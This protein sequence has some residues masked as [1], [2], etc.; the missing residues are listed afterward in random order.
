MQKFIVE[1]M[2]AI[3]S[4]RE[5]GMGMKVKFFLIKGI[6]DKCPTITTSIPETGTESKQPIAV[7]TIILRKGRNDSRPVCHV[8]FIMETMARIG[9]IQPNISSKKRVK[10]VIPSLA[11]DAHGPALT[12]RIPKTKAM[13][14]ICR[15]YTG[16]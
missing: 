2:H 6:G 8:I 1:G 14:N 11:Q 5:N 4:H 12:N 16:S 3:E 9:I 7:A 15:T 10:K 13:N